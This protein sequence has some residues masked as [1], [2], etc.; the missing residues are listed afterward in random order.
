M[1]LTEQLAALEKGRLQLQIPAVRDQ[2]RPVRN[3]HFHLFPEMFIQMSGQTIMNV[4]DKTL[5]L[6]PGTVCIVPRGVPHQE[7][8]QAL[9]GPFRNMVVMFRPKQVSVHLADEGPGHKPRMTAIE[10]F[11][12]PLGLRLKDHL[13]EISAVHHAFGTEEKT[14]VRGLLMAC[15]AI[16]IT[17]LKGRS[18]GWE[19]EHTRIARCRQLVMSNLSDPTLSISKLAGWMQ[20]SADYLSHLFRTQTG[21]RLAVYINQQRIGHARYLLA[22]TDSSIKEVAWASGYHD[23][24]YFIRVFRRI[25]GQTP[26]EY[27]KNV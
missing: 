23:P 12:T 18:V 21:T 1:V 25:T 9:K 5:Q 20:C 19:K 24:G 3:A 27:R 11:E 14:A 26:K 13:E 16:L 8:A 10:Y 2:L 15:F 22:D 7:E 17:I 4:P 6:A